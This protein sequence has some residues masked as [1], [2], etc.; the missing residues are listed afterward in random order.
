VLFLY[1]VDDKKSLAR[2]E[3]RNNA[4]Q[5]LWN[6]HFQQALAAVGTNGA[7]FLGTRSYPMKPP[8]ALGS[9]SAVDWERKIGRRRKKSWTT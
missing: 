2:N 6:L 9:G 1:S 5:R 7:S 8:A 3:P 4:E